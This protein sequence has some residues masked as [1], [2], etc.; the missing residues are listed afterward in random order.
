MSYYHSGNYD[1]A[2]PCFEKTYEIDPKDI[3]TL[4][5]LCFATSEYGNDEL[6]LNIHKSLKL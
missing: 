2:I 6:F 4:L 5:F 1:E 3:D